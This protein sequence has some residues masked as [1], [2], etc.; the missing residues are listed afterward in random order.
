MFCT[1]KGMTPLANTAILNRLEAKGLDKATVGRVEKPAKDR[2]ELTKS[3]FE[4]VKR[5]ES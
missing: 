5:D 4:G 1:L 2:I 3:K